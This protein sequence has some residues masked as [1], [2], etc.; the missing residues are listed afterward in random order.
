MA[1]MAAAVNRDSTSLT[2]RK[3]EAD[4]FKLG[5]FSKFESDTILGAIYDYI[6]R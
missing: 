3:P 5:K 6:E 2:V 4:E 1:N